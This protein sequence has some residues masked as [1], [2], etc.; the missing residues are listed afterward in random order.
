MIYRVVAESTVLVWPAPDTEPVEVPGRLAGAFTAALD[1]WA[2]LPYPPR[3]NP[4][5]RFWF[6]EAG[7]R[8]YGRDVA[9][10][11]EASGRTYRVVRRKNPPDSAVVYRDRWQVAV[12]P[13][14]DR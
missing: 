8:R 14:R 5:A 12:L 3:V 1:G 9:A 7:W 4:R 6:T 13:Q 10:A 2:D 11:A